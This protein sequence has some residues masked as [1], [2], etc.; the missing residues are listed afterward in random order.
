MK[1]KYFVVFI[2]FLLTVSAYGHPKPILRDNKLSF[3]YRK[4]GLNKKQAAIHLLNRFTYGVKPG[5]IEQVKDLGLEKWFKLQLSS[6]LSDE[7]LNNKISDL[8]AFNMDNETI[9][10]SFVPLFEIR[11]LMKEEGILIDSN[12]DKP[13]FKKTIDSFLKSKNLRLPAEYQRQLINHKILSATYS[14]NQLAEIMTDF[15]FNHFNVSLS[16]NQ[17]ATHI[18]AYERDVIRP[19]ILGNFENLLI[20]TAKSPAMLEYLDN[21]S[22][23]SFNNTLSKI[24]LN[25]R[26]AKASESQTNP[27]LDSGVLKMLKQRKDQGLNENYARE[28]LELHTLG[29]NGGYTQKDVTEVARIFTGWSVVPLYK[30]SAYR[31]TFDKA[32]KYNIE[33]LGFIIDG[34]FLYR[35]NRHD[36]S[37]KTVLNYQFP[38]NG[39]YEEGIQL[40]K[41]LA[42]HPSTAKFICTKIATR[43]VSD[44]P[45][46]NLIEKM[47]DTYLKFDGNIEKVLITMVN[48]TEFWSDTVMRK[49]VKTPF[50]FVISSLR[51]TNAEIK[52][53]YQLYNWCSNMGQRFYNYQAP[54]GFPDRASFWINTSSLLSRMN[55][56]IA[57]A[58]NKLVGIKM[59]SSLVNSNYEP[60]SIE[61]AI[62]N[63]SE[64]ILPEVNSDKNFN[65]ILKL[66]KDTEVV[67]KIEAKTNTLLSVDHSNPSNE[68]IETNSNKAITTNQDRNNKLSQIIGLLIGSPEFQ[69]R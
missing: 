51:A 32:R 21:A 65:R 38:E 7:E 2:S 20:A 68:N 24:E 58:S 3:P 69:N 52:N 43:F 36:D 55:F 17:C 12:F 57:Y 50:E 42:V 28:L 66:T 15:W 25:K 37:S 39:G 47:T 48:D 62:H 8:D 27:L 56:G 46:T 1:C 4:M 44:H 49:K 45:S 33:K 40:L 22:S 23:V 29:V 5:D 59:D 63:F 41:Q 14:N 26:I 67:N 10:N 6:Q 54:T 60:E 35:A 30:N 11:K 9:Q 19:N 18:L 31:K 53:P 64:L 34:D 16:K 13:F 61:V